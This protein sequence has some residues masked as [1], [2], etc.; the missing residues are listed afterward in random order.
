MLVSK[1]VPD[2]PEEFLFE[3]A[4][5]VDISSLMYGGIINGM[6]EKMRLTLQAGG[7]LYY[8]ILCQTSPPI[9]SN[10]SI[11]LSLA[12]TRSRLILSESFEDS[13]LSPVQHGLYSM[14]L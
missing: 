14:T 4:R 3:G 6:S 10:D 9:H 2:K 5:D 7:P 13:Y 11:L 1:Q 8:V 12:I